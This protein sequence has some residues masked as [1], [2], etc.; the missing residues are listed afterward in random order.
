MCIRDRRWP[1]SPSRIPPSTSPL[2]GLRGQPRRRAARSR[3]R[4][5]ARRSRSWR[6]PLSTR[7]RC[8]NAGRWRAVP[9]TPPPAAGSHHR[10]STPSDVTTRALLARECVCCVGTS[11]DAWRGRHLRTPSKSRES[12]VSDQSS[13][14]AGTIVNRGPIPNRSRIG[15]SDC[16]PLEKCQISVCA[17]V[18][19][20]G[21]PGHF[22]GRKRILP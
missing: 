18:T 5:R 4:P 22:P 11:D 17:S 8:Q 1:V 15:A 21:D 7:P 3:P 9:S 2:P 12:S 6:Q 14:A 20:R 19:S 10:R 13:P 16:L